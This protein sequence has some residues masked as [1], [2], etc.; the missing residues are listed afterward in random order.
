MKGIRVLS[1]NHEKK[2]KRKPQETVS[3]ALLPFRFDCIKYAH[4]EQKALVR[5]R[6]LQDF[7]RRAG[8]IENLV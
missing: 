1:Y 6:R 3:A 8:G 2:T 4:P 7:W 5:H